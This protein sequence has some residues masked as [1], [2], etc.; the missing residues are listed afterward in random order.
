[1]PDHG[2]VQLPT[3]NELQEDANIEDGEIINTGDVDSG[4]E[5]INPIDATHENTAG[6]VDDDVVMEPS[7]Q[8]FPMQQAP[9]SSHSSSSTPS[10]VRDSASISSYTSLPCLCPP[11]TPISTHYSDQNVVSLN[12][13]EPLHDNQSDGQYPF[14]LDF[15][16][17]VFNHST[18][19]NDSDSDVS[20]SNAMKGLRVDSRG[21]SPA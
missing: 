12:S 19:P 3:E 7:N 16:R 2:D 13:L 6:Q 17:P 18:M 1:V 10:F 20:A 21:G 8:F 4:Q 9:V 14:F 11:I 15:K 5:D